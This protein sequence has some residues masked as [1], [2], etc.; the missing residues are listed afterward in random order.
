[1]TKVFIYAR[2]MLLISN[3]VCCQTKMW[4]EKEE[5][6]IFGKKYIVLAVHIQNRPI[7]KGFSNYL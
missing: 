6:Q 1:M 4:S 2:D 3:W 5:E 7:V